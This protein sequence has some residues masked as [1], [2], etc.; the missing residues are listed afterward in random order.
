[1]VEWVQEQVS[2]WL[3]T[4]DV[5]RLEFLAGVIFATSEDISS[6]LSHLAASIKETWGTA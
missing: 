5:F 3:K 6:D 4:D 1:M 2:K